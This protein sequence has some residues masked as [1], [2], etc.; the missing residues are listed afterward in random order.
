MAMLRHPR[1]FVITPNPDYL[2]AGSRAPEPIFIVNPAELRAELGMPKGAAVANAVV[3][4][5]GTSAGTQLNLLLT[6]LRAA[7][8]IA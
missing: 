4:T 6:S 8:I 3:A 2:P 5:D 7:G 1:P